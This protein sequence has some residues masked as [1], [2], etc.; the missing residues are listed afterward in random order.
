MNK[1][2]VFAWLL[3]S[4]TALGALAQSST[5]ATIRGKVMNERGSALPA[6]EIDA[7]NTATGF[8]KTVQAG[9]DGSY[10]LQ[11]LVPGTYTVVIA[12][13]GYEPRNE[14]ITV[15]VGQSL[16]ADFRMTGTAVVNESITVVG[17][18]AV[19]TKTTEVA[20]NV[21]TQQ[22]ESLPQD[23]R[24]FLN[25]AALAPGVR[26]SLDPLRKTFTGDAQNA[27]Q[28]NVFI[29]GVSNKN[30]VLQG[31]LAGQDTSRG[32]PFPQN[33]VQEFRVITQNYGAQYDHASSA[34]ITAVTKSGG[35]N[36][37]GQAF[38]YYQ[39]KNW[40]APTKKSFQF[41]TLAT[42]ATYHRTQ[43]GLNFGG[44]IVKD[45]LHFFTAWEG[46]D[47]HATSQVS[48][49]LTD[50]AFVSQF[51]SELG[52]FPGP[53]RSNLGFGKVSWQ[54]DKSQI[55]DFSGSYRHEREIRDFG[56]ARSYQA[57]NEIVNEVYGVT[58]RHQWNNASAL[59]EAILSV[60][61]YNWNQQPLNPDVVG[62]LYFNPQ[63][64]T[65]L[66]TGGGDT[67]QQFNQRRVELRDNFNFAPLERAGGTHNFQI[68]GNVDFMH[69][70]VNKNLFGNPLYKF[71]PDANNQF[72]NIPFE[73]QFGIGN[74]KLGLSNR[75]YGIYGQDNWTVNNKLTL[76]I[77]LRWDY[78]THML[79]EDFVTPA[80]IVSALKGKTFVFEGR[81]ITIP[82]AY[83]STGTERKPYKNEYQPRLG[84]SYDLRGDSRSVLFG[85]YG[86]YYDRIFLNSTLD[87]RFRQQFPVYTFRFSPT[88]DPANHVIKWDP[89]YFTPEGLR[90]LIAAG[91]TT[92]EVYL[93]NNNTKPPYSKQWNIG[94]RQTFGDWLGTLNYSNVNARRGLTWVAA[95]GFDFGALGG[96]GFELLSDPQGRSNWYTGESIAID[97]PYN[98]QTHWGLH[99][100]YTHAVAEQNGND[101][102]EFDLPRVSQIARHPVEGSEPNRWFV[103][104][105]F[106]LPWDVRFSTN[107][108]LSSGGAKPIQ[109][110]SK[111]FDFAGR[112]ATGVWNGAVYPQGSGS[113]GY[114]D[115]SLRL[116]KQFA[117]VHG[118]SLAVIADMFNATNSTN[119]GCLN[120]FLPANPSPQ[121]LANIGVPNCVVSLG[122]R[123]QIGLRLNF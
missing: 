106:G 54:I 109:D 67:T 30:D 6:A 73:A 8:V 70:D 90:A 95:S 105:I 119:Y 49:G 15:L 78:E 47:E 80:N 110:F 120:N 122:R 107:I 2:I 20:T 41:S 121:D 96:L 52:V 113:F 68:G 123:E 13:P 84:F 26:V 23:D 46:V 31:G 1:K 62:R 85:G 82:D 103:S 40:V 117:L 10:V 87:E 16:T 83:F 108:T 92:P 97:R 98:A 79:D 35:N 58:G 28:T 75:E 50:P 36:F 57:A 34:I 27:E 60:Q 93:L 88:G 65:I 51:G 77:G 4:L 18:Q 29:D 61:K 45:K 55:A 118:T 63:F 21:T 53:F 48:L 94:Y 32:N 116:E 59:N 3:V 9:S 38:L 66:R 112:L 17:T 33:A 7:V 22:I 91:N 56:S 89:S 72:G 42:N 64:V 19:E 74:P 44:P 25:F 115:V 43:P 81:N 69:Y 37:D 102:F 24:N 71:L 100:T 14:T 101:L 5:T 39:P 76:N 104:G 12:A 99:F 114:R 86:K 111:G 11:G